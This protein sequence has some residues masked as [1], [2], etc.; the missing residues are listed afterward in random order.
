[1]KADVKKKTKLL[2]NKVRKLLGKTKEQ[3][4]DELLLYCS[5][6]QTYVN[7]TEEAK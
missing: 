3:L 2:L 6:V 5:L 7:L 1:M 4:P